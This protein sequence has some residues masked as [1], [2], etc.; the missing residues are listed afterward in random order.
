VTIKGPA[1]VAIPICVVLL[2]LAVAVWYALKRPRRWP[3]RLSLALAMAGDAFWAVEF[4]AVLLSGSS[5]ASGIYR[6]FGML[7]LL[8]AGAATASLVGLALGVW[9]MWGE[10]RSDT[11]VM[12]MSLNAV[13]ATFGLLGLL[14]L[15]PA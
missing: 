10:G 1:V 4:C 13:N 3:T 5:I 15:I 8:F 9:S 6:G 12:A 14:T 7:G 11:T 2:L